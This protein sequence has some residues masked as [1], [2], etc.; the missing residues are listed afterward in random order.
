MTHSMTT[1]QTICS[2]LTSLC[3][4]TELDFSTNTRLSTRNS[5]RLPWRV[6]DRL[7]L[8]HQLCRGDPVWLYL[9]GVLLQD[10]PNSL[11]INI[12]SRSL[13]VN[14]RLK[15]H[16]YSIPSSR[17]RTSQAWT[18]LVT[19]KSPSKKWASKQ[20]IDSKLTATLRTNT[21]TSRITNRL[22]WWR[23][24]TTME[25]LA[26]TW[27]E[28]HMISHKTKNLSTRTATR[29]SHLCLKSWESILRR[30]SKNS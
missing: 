20:T 1:V 23:I 11:W 6:L 29:T 10:L 27:E 18:T 22:P 9:R 13:P 4:T 14:N 19:I 24:D 16:T 28:G 26:T 21:M 15:T 30:S 25:T 7:R 3:K 17:L 2:W 12:F 5:Q 8:L